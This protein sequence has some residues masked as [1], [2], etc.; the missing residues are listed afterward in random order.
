MKTNKY[1]RFFAILRQVN[2]NGLELTKEQAVFDFTNK[3]TNSLSSLSPM[4][5]RA[6][7]RSLSEMLIKEVSRLFAEAAS[8]ARAMSPALMGTGAA[9]LA[10]Q[11][12][13][14]SINKPVHD[15]VRDKMRKAIISQFKAIGK[16]T[17]HAIAWA[18]KYGVGGEKRLFN[19]Y[20]EQELYQLI[21]NAEKMKSDFIN[22]LNK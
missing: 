10:T 6:L 13:P 20:S 5:V 2:A 3:R 11:K 19:D 21:R 7:E 18:E 8:P 14:V 15:P 22:S 9:R 1:A 12:R 16:T 17:N 4:E